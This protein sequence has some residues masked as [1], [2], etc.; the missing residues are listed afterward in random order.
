MKSVFC[1]AVVFSLPVCTLAQAPPPGPSSEIAP[2]R[3][4]IDAALFYQVLLGELNVQGG[5]PGAGFSLL[6][7]AA[8]KTNDS[9]LY[10][11][12][13]DVAL[14]SRAGDAALQAAKA[15]RQAQPTSREAR[16]INLQILIA[17]NRTGE[18]GELLAAEIA[19]VPLKDRPLAILVIPRSFLRISD[20]QLA[21]LVVEKALEPHLNHPG[22]SAAAWVTIGRMRLLA[23]NQEGALEAARK[24]QEIDPREEGAARI[25]VEVMGPTQPL[26]EAIVLKYLASEPKP[27]PEVRMALVRALINAHRATDALK[28]TQQLVAE[29]PAYAPAWLALGLLQ[30]DNRNDSAEASL[31]RYLEL[32]AT[33]NDEAGRRGRTEALLVLAQIAEQRQ[34]FAGASQ[35]LDRIENQEDRSVQTRRAS[36]LARQGHLDQAR[37][38]IRA[39]PT[40]TPADTR[41]KLLAEVQLLRESRQ[42]ETAFA[43]LGTAIEQQPGEVDLLY[44]QALIAEK[45][46]KFETMER[47]LRQLI[48]AKPD[49]HHA[50]NALG[51]SLAERGVRLEE[52]RQLIQKAIEFAP[53]DP[54][55]R[56]S[57]GW[58]EFRSG[59]NA[60][61][62]H[63]LQSAFKAR[64]D[65]EIAAHLGEV[66]WTMGEREQAG[67]I[68]REGLLLSP[69]NETLLNTLKRLRATP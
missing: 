44:D 51:Y 3:S 2:A 47:L 26:A 62:L 52:A 42:L 46:G 12:A 6:L 1:L 49:Y 64:P 40:R 54:M 63:L 43:L 56:D 37:E 24:T 7:D 61:A 31:K 18:I 25:A 67:S 32:A 17:L 55:I 38:L 57:L 10:Q 60:E 41:L 45:L 65:A 69:E 30:Q 59:N 34:D 21:A 14:E 68:W 13:V 35:W 11:R 58:V 15:W 33:Y 36:L 27:E 66:L 9:A 29:Q 28:Q 8:R 50:Y 20:R 16:R 4:Q 53:D 19:A 5:E 23:N 39:W 22:T 48:A